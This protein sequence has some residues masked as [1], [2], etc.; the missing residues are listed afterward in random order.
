MRKVTCAD[1]GKRYDYDTDGFCPRCGSFN[2]PPDGGATRLEQELLARF[3]P[4]S[5]SAPK[6]RGAPPPRTA[7]TRP[8]TA[9]QAKAP[10]SGPRTVRYGGAPEPPKAKKRRSSA[11][12]VL[13]VVIIV[14]LLNL[15]LPFLSM[16]ISLFGSYHDYGSSFRVPF[17]GAAVELPVAAAAPFRP[18]TGP[19]L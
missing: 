15:L 13:L 7:P 4:R 11:R 8:T 19:F 3:Q 9:A 18:E 2:P 16:L 12:I 14:I 10:V 5:G 1:C 6:G 17:A